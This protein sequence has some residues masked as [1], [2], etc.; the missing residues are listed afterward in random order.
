M[1]ILMNYLNADNVKVVT[2]FGPPGFGKSEL[3]LHIGHTMIKSGVD[4]YYIDVMV[5]PSLDKLI[6]KLVNI[7]EIKVTENEDKLKGWSKTIKKNSLLILDNL[8]G[9]QWAH[10]DALANFGMNFTKVVLNTAN[11]K[12]LITSQ[13]KIT[14]PSKFR[15]YRLDPPS[16]A[17][18][19]VMFSHFVSDVSDYFVTDDTSLCAIG[20]PA[21]T[22]KDKVET[23]CTLVGNVPMALKVLASALE[24]SVTID[25]V[26]KRLEEKLKLL[27][28]NETTEPGERNLLSAFEVAFEFVKL[29]YQICC[30]LLTKFPGYLTVEITEPVITPELLAQYNTKKVFHMEECF[31]ELDRKSFIESTIIKKNGGS[32]KLELLYYFHTLTRDYLNITK[33]EVSTEVLHT[34]WDKYFEKA[35]TIEDYEWLRDDLSRED[36]EIIVEFL[37]C[38]GYHSHRLAQNLIYNYNVKHF[39][40]L[41]KTT[42]SNAKFVDSAVALLLGDCKQP[43]LTYN[44]TN[45]ATLLNTYH[46]IFMHILP[47]DMN[48]M[49]KLAMCEAKVQQFNSQKESSDY[50]ALFRTFDFYYTVSAKCESIGNS[51][52]ICKQRWKYNLLHFSRKYILVIHKLTQYCNYELRTP[53]CT[54]NLASY[55]TGG[56]V[57]YNEG[58]DAMAEQYLLL[59]LMDSS[60]IE[61]KPLHDAILNIMLYSIYKRKG[62]LAN[63]EKVLA[64]IKTINFQDGNIDCFQGIINGILIPF[65]ES[66]DEKDMVSSLLEKYNRQS[67]VSAV[68]D[69]LMLKPDVNRSLEVLDIKDVIG[70]NMES[71]EAYKAGYQAGQATALK[72]TPP[73]IQEEESQ[74]TPKIA[75]EILEAK[76]SLFCFVAKDMIPECHP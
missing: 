76:A 19:V 16:L 56:I 30:L 53:S 22:T 31:K 65:L 6:E 49:D 33:V 28:F 55:T 63:A 12:M 9:R 11:L 26:I 74:L 68:G 43:S 41:G 4:V 71:D 17:N 1:K 10:V 37:G 66:C 75:E 69:E 5:L 44:T 35:T 40:R 3:A 50:L 62:N 60:S 57:S 36:S 47:Q 45:I 48:Y 18:C 42:D 15:W 14:A 52:D 29:E 13:Q 34:F 20:D 67:A 38:G 23:V 59:A 70:S 64:T 21:C 2:L 61:C 51:H 54:R 58:K 39:L 32:A 25:Y 73:F 46:N 7:S 27:Y 8:D 24:K 72:S